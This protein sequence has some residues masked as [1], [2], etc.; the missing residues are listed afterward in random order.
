VKFLKRYAFIIWYGIGMSMIFDINTF[1]SWQGW[2]M[3][4]PLILLVEW[5]AY[6]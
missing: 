2:V 3:T 6:K 5:K 1:K 4:I